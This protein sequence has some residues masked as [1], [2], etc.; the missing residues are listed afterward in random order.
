MQVTSVFPEVDF[1]HRT[2]KDLWITLY[3]TP[4]QGFPQLW[5]TPVDSEVS[6]LFTCGQNGELDVTRK[7]TKNGA[8]LF[9]C[10][11]FPANPRV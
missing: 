8:N 2:V 9:F 5:I 6:E 7:M 11:L 10:G 4:P 3:T 1:V